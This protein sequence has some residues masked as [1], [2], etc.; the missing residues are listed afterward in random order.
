MVLFH[1]SD[2]SVQLPTLDGSGYEEPIDLTQLSALNLLD[3]CKKHGLKTTPRNK[4]H[5]LAEIQKQNRTAAKQDLTKPDSKVGPDIRAWLRRIDDMVPDPY[6][7][8]SSAVLI[9]KTFIHSASQQATAQP[10]LD[11]SVLLLPSVPFSEKFEVTL[12]NGLSIKFSAADIAAYPSVTMPKASEPYLKRL[13]CFW[14]DDL[15]TWTPNICPKVNGTVLPAK[16]WKKVFS[17]AG[18][19]KKGA[20]RTQWNRWKRLVD[21]LAQ[22]DYKPEALCDNTLKVILEQSARE[23]LT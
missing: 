17:K 22:Y 3:L 14:D 4:E 5:Y 16:Y 20:H 19:W 15:T 10:M 1:E 8:V 13:L 21:T 2:K 9:R 7:L 11:S 12:S 6:G 18:H 23:S